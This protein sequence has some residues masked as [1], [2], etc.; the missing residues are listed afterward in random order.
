M[1]L[2]KNILDFLILNKDILDS[3]PR[4]ANLLYIGGHWRKYSIMAEPVTF[5][6]NMV[7]ASLLCMGFMSGSN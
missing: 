2:N 7:M 4:I 5:S 6:Y 1:H 3:D